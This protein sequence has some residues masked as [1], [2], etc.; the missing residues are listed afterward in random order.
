MAHPFTGAL[1]VIFR[2]LLQGLK[3]ELEASE[4]ATTQGTERVATQERQV[5]ELR[6]ELTA[7]REDKK[8]LQQELNSL[9]QRVDVPGDE[10]TAA[11]KSVGKTRMPFGEISQNATPAKTPTAQKPLKAQQDTASRRMTRSMRRSIGSE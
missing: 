9:K 6:E 1:E 10:N 7:S 5:A 11:P 4:G 8:Q 2:R 3:G